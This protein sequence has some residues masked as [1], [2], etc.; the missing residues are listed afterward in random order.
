MCTC[1]RSI[2]LKREKEKKN[3]WPKSLLL[4]PATI[5]Y[6]L[7]TF[8]L[9]PSRPL[10]LFS[11]SIYLL[12]VLVVWIPALLLLLLA[13]RILFGPVVLQRSHY[14]AVQSS[15]ALLPIRCNCGGEKHGDRMDKRVDVVS[16]AHTSP[17]SL[18]A[19]NK[20]GWYYVC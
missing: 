20:R 3:P 8:L 16:I 11:V 1:R 19:A 13:G 18:C 17:L 15:A 4:Q 10:F 2:R 6:T 14:T 12:V 5:I 7:S 9:F